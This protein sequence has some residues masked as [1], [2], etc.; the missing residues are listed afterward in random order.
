L[1]DANENRDW[2]IYADFAQIL[3]AQARPLH[4]NDSFGVEL[5][6]TAYAL[7]STTIDLCLSLFPWAHFRKTK[8]AVK[9]HTLLNL[10]RSI[11]EL[12]H[13]STGKLHDVNVLDILAAQPGTF[14]IMDKA[15]VDFGHLCAMDMSQAFFVTR[16]KRRMLYR[17]RYSRKA[18]KDLTYN[19]TVVLWELFKE[20]S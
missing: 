11:P 7:D 5:D 10:R 3:I 16:A 20:I 13:I 15:Y 6:S 4:Q 14:Y 1:A 12:V 18:E 17:R 19:R 2:R 8:G 9:L